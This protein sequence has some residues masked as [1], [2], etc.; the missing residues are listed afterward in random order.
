MLPDTFRLL[1]L[2]LPNVQAASSLGT[3]EFRVVGKVFAS[4]GS[5]MAGQAMI[6]LTRQDQALFIQEAPSVFAPKPG[7]PGARGET[8]VKLATAEVDV[9]R[10][11]L[12][13][14]CRKATRG[15]G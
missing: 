11:A 14:A 4:L 8:I 5:P 1:A 15:K 9:L 12:A 2:N 3:E 10:R 6:K 7:G 13:A